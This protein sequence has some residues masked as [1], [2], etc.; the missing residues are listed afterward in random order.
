MECGEVD[1]RCYA[2][3]HSLAPHEVQRLTPLVVPGVDAGSLLVDRFPAR[4]AAA[5]RALCD[6][7]A[8][9]FTGRQT[10]TTLPAL[11]PFASSSASHQRVNVLDA[12]HMELVLSSSRKAALQA[13]L[14]A[15]EVQRCPDFASH[16]SLLTRHLLLSDRVERLRQSLDESNLSHM[17]DYRSKL[18]LLHRLDYIDAELHVQLKGRVA[19]ELNTCDSLIGT[20]LIFGNALGDLTPQETVSRSAAS[21]SATTSCSHLH[22]RAPPTTH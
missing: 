20:E 14:Q 18:E 12:G 13:Q 21:A 10:W 11:E 22:R 2:L 15:S 5:V 1:G 17:A 6:V 9:H 8:E 7:E 4:V 16:L 19:C 3:L